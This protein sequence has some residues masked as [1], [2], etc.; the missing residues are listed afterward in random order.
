MKIYIVMSTS[1]HKSEYT[2]HEVYASEEK[3]RQR[4]DEL[5]AELNSDYED[6]LEDDMDFDTGW[7]VWLEEREVIE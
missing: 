4:E 6:E 5:L 1:D 2:V 3:A 7:H